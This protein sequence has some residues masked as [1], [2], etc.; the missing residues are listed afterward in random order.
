MQQALL[1]HL[2]KI[3]EEEQ[4]ILDGASEVDQG[5]Y[6]SGKDFTVDSAKMLEEGKLIAVRT[7]TRFVHFPPHR[8]NFIEVLYVC[9][10]S[11]TNIIGGKQVV[12]EAGELLF[13]NQFTRHEILPAGKNDI[14]I[15]FMI[16]PEFFDVAYTMAGS[17]NVLADFLVNVLRQNEEKG[18]YLHFR[19][20]EVLQIQ[21]LLENMI[22]SLVTGRGDQ[23]RINQTTMGLIF[24][25]L[26][27]SVQ[28]AEMRV[29]NQYENMISMTTL[30]YIEQNYKTATLTELCVR[31]H[32][33]MHVLS[34]M[35][36]KN[37]GFNFKELLQRKRM[38]K[39]IEL[40]CE[41]E[42]PIS[43]IIAAVG[44]ENGSY[45]HR[46]FREKYHVTPRA[47]R[48]INRKRET[49]RL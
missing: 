11:L 7:H 26:L 14:A 3:T 29:P 32:L 47:F 17:N 21:N 20:A 39:A 27:D 24:L 8:H 41:T 48:E 25:Y 36:K 44:Y 42:L 30:D 35:I 5:L 15:N 28:Y 4:R 1:D 45:F 23:N 22:Y 19:V 9:E 18:E 31:L 13:L 49:V 38:N 40:M 16:L 12:I 43:D 6:T 2:R 34:K 10:G 46:V 37:T 33:P